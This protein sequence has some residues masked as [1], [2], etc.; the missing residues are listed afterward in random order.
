MLDAVGIGQT[1]LFAKNALCYNG[2]EKA[3]LFALFS[4]TST[5]TTDAILDARFPSHFTFHRITIIPALI[6]LTLISIRN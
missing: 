6:V 2:L 3:S 4:S 1:T 5:I